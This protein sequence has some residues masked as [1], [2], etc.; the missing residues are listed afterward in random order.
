MMVCV[1]RSISNNTC[2]EHEPGCRHRW[3]NVSHMIASA[4]SC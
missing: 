2:T 4:M 3:W 1:H